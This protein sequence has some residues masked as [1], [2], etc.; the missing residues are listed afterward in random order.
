M[1]SE[2]SPRAVPLV[3]LSLLQRLVILDRGTNQRLQ[4][5]CIDTEVSGVDRIQNDTASY[6]Q[7]ESV[8]F[9]FPLDISAGQFLHFI[10]SQRM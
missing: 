1:E 3:P 10:V 8:E 4:I 9:R 7:L 5:P 2:L 6:S